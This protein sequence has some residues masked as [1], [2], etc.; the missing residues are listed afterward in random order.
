MRDLGL[1]LLVLGGGGY[2]VRNVARCWTHETAV[3]TR[4]ELAATVPNNEYLEYFA[5]DYLL[6]PELPAR[7]ENGNTRPHLASLVQQVQDLLRLTAHAPAV[8][9]YDSGAKETGEEELV[10]DLKYS[11]IDIKDEAIV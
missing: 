4:A 7:H 3:L 8:Q 10:P 1:P 2:T 11:E 5:P 6:L 9:M